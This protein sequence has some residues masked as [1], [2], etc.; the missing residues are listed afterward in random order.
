[1]LIQ[2]LRESLGPKGG[3]CSIYKECHR[4]TEDEFMDR[5]DKDE[6]P[7]PVPL[8]VLQGQVLVVAAESWIAFPNSKSYCCFVCKGYIGRIC[9]YTSEEQKHIVPFSRYKI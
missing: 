3:F 7:A 9:S 2:P 4:L 1:M 6:L 8:Q 5:F